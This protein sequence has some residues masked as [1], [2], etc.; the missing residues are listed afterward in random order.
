MLF[1]IDCALYYCDIKIIIKIVL[2]TAVY[3]ANDYQHIVSFPDPP[4]YIYQEGLGTRL[5]EAAACDDLH[6]GGD[7][8][9]VWQELN[10]LNLSFLVQFNL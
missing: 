8:L 1:C 5:G 6:G 9:C 4:V 10:C 7:H 3:N 2:V